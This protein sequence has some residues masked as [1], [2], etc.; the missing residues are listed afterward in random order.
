MKVMNKVCKSLIALV[1]C[2]TSVFSLSINLSA[3]EVSNNLALNK[4][5][6]A[7]AEY[8]T[9]PASNLTDADE[10]SRWSTERDATQWA[11]VD[12]GQEYEM[13]KFQ[14]IWESDSVYAQEYN[15]YVSNDTENWG[16]AVIQRT[17]NTAQ[18]SEDV[19]EEAVSGRYVKLEIIAV[20]NY[21]SVSCRE[22][23][24]IQVKGNTSTQHPAENVALNKYLKLI[25]DI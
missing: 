12:L 9:M 19:L 10:D 20:S 7:S 14:M 2:L 11:Y 21:P 3:E 1:L 18:T 23:K 4:P 8:S 15:I 5:V 25:C 13:N 24:I 16:E 22:F 6:V 17:D